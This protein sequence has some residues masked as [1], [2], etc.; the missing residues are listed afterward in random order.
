MALGLI[1][2]TALP[3][4]LL[5]HEGHDHGAA[6]PAAPAAASPRVT[7]HSDAYELVGVLRDGRLRVYLDR[8]AT[9]EP[10]TDARIAVTVGGD[11]EVQAEPAPDGTYALSSPKLGGQGP[12]EL[13]FAVTGAS[14]DD[15]LIGILQLPAKPVAAAP[16]PAPPGVLDA[17]RNVSVVRVGTVEV[18]EAYLIAGVA[19]ALG[20]LLGI[21]VRSGGRLVPAT[22]LGLILLLATTAYAYS[23]GSNAA[24]DAPRRL[25]D[26]TLFVPKPSQHL[27]EVRTTVAKPEAAAKAV[28]LIGRVIADANRGGMVQ[29]LTGG[30]IVPAATGLPRVG[31][32]VRKGEVL[33]LIERPLPPSTLR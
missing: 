28:N 7:V 2:I 3:A 4:A 15:L 17:F 33:A 24:G 11:E 32:A 10:V 23:Q 20:F 12:L 6:P 31:Q 5:A 19:L 21:A 27:L 1:V 8:F 18:A 13:I 26:G 14:G 22:G 30:R 16:A 29:S 25:P 9:N